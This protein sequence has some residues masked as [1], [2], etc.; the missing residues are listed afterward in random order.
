MREG[1]LPQSVH[2]LPIAEQ[3]KHVW[4]KNW[5][6]RWAGPHAFLTLG[7]DFVV[8]DLTD[9]RRPKELSRTPL[10]RFGLSKQ[11]EESIEKLYH[12]LAPGVLPD[13]GSLQLELKNPELLEGLERRQYGA[14]GENLYRIA[15][16]PGLGP[17]SLSGEKS[18]CPAILARGASRAGHRRPA[19]TGGGRIRSR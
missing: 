7:H 13:F 9:P 4:P 10:R 15:V 17:I 5:E 14:Y 2:V 11:Y 19:S 8:L 3:A 1:G 16:S 12:Q 18:V 6:M